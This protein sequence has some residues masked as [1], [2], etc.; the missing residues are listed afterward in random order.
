MAMSS[1]VTVLEKP[2]SVVFF[3]IQGSGKG[4]Q[5][6]LLADYI[7]RNSDLGILRIEMGERLR[8]FAA[9]NSYTNK[10]ISETLNA[11]KLLPAFI[12]DYMLTSFFLQEFSGTEHVIL[13]GV[14][15]KVDQA[16]MMD[17]A[18]SFFDRPD[19]HAIV[20]ELSHDDAKERLRLR[21]RSD[22]KSDA[23]IEERLAAFERDT[24]PA[25]AEIER[26]G[27]TVH[28]VDGRPSIEDIHRQVLE[29]L[30]IA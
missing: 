27:R 2:L 28:R 25:I 26:R 13:D 7:E 3:G 18:F 4:T 12:P 10:K 9:G 23:Q 19:Y 11:G 6:G 20:L 21:G 22:D 5:A 17:E 8:G 30:N 15:R 1:G 16:V 29:V 14:A 24:V